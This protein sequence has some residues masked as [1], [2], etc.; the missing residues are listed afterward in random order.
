MAF[1]C[2]ILKDSPAF[3]GQWHTQADAALHDA[4]R[5]RAALGTALHEAQS[6]LSL[7]QHQ[8]E[9]VSHVNL[10]HHAHHASRSRR[11]GNVDTRTHLTLLILLKLPQISA[12]ARMEQSRAEVAEAM[13]MQLQDELL[14]LRCVQQDVQ[15]LTAVAV[16]LP[17]IDRTTTLATR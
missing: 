17:C 1:T 2:G 16:T 7:V 5:E 9:E 3:A 8:Q 12:D 14:T 15:Q 10:G 6:S 4:R 13:R 11:M